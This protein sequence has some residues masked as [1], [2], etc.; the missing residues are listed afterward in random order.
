MSKW[1]AVY[2]YADGLPRTYL[3]DEGHLLRRRKLRAAGTD[4][5]GHLP[6]RGPRVEQVLKGGRGVAALAG[7][8]QHKV[9]LQ[10]SV[11]HRVHA[12]A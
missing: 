3:T 10:A 8:M 4:R 6:G 1:L 2:D 11:C 7:K 9:R 12:A 5:V